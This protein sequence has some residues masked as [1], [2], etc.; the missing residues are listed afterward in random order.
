[1]YNF[2]KGI[3]LILEVSRMAETVC[4]ELDRQVATVLLNRPEAFNAFDL[5]MVELFANRLTT[6]AVDNSVRGIVISGAGKGFCVGGGFEV[7]P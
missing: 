5:D 3:A 7:G 6:L 1:V 4:I 2:T